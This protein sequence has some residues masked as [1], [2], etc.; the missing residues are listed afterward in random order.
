M[1]IHEALDAFCA[2]HKYNC[3][4]IFLCLCIR[5]YIHVCVYVYV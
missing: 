1:Y 5:V 3:I 4:Y 2:D